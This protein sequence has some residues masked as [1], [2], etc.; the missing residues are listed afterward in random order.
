MTT[1]ARKYEYAIASG[2]LDVE[3]LAVEKD[4]DYENERTIW[5]FE[6]ESAIWM[7]SSNEIGVITHYGFHPDNEQL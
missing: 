6:D 7:N 1:L 2:H 4:Q 5:I 3:D